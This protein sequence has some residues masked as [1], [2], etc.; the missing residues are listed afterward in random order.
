[1]NWKLMCGVGAKTNTGYV[2]P[3]RTVCGISYNEQGFVPVLEFEKP[4]LKIYS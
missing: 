1:M 2:V 3:Q 4:M